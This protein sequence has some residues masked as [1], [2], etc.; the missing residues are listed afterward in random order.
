[1]ASQYYTPLEGLLPYL[2]H[3][4]ELISFFLFSH[5]RCVAIFVLCFDRNSGLGCLVHR[6]E[7][8]F[9]VICFPY[10]FRCLVYQT[11]YNLYSEG[12]TVSNQIYDV[13]LLGMSL[14]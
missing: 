9:C 11:H 5:L 2:S 14:N 7:E 10:L 6:S 8:Y 3:T 1:M 13:E 12:E 4:Y